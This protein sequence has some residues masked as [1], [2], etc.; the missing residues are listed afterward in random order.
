MHSL[1]LIKI[2]VR[3]TITCNTC[4]Q[5]SIQEDQCNILQLPVCSSV[6]EAVDLSLKT[7]ELDGHNRYFCNFCSSLQPASLEHALANFES[8][9]ILQLKRFDNFGDSTSKDVRP[10]KCDQVVK[11]PLTVDNDI[12]TN[13]RFQLLASINHSGSPDRGHYTANIKNTTSSDWFHCNDA[14]VLH[15]K[16]NIP[17][18]L[19]YILFYI[20]C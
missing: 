5:S 10:V 15:C 4:F 7:E 9:L 20:A 2:Q 16:E 1:N 3:N 13:K 18:D 8:L 11:L 12:T 17:Q 6:Q 14:A 19:S